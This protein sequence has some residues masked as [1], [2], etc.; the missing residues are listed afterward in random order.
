[1]SQKNTLLTVAGILAVCLWCF[2]AWSFIEASTN[3]KTWNF[4]SR[5]FCAMIATAGSLLVFTAINSS[6][7]DEPK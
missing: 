1:M 7:K 5:V 3:I 4:A 6:T 2:F